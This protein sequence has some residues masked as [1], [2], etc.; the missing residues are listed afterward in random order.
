[1][2]DLTLRLYRLVAKGTTDLGQAAQVSIPD[3]PLPSWM[4]LDKLLTLFVFLFFHLQNEGS[5][6]L[7][8]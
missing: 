1:V 7:L 8:P 6:S 4:T 2:G 5:D 3:L